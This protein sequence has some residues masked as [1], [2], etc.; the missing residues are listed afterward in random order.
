MKTPNRNGW[1]LGAVFADDEMRLNRRGQAT[2]GNYLLK[3][4]VST[5]GLRSYNWSA[6]CLV[7]NGLTLWAATFDYRILN[8]NDLRFL[9]SQL[10]VHS[11]KMDPCDLIRD[12][13]P[14]M[15][16]PSGLTA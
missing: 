8:R 7:Y 11:G 15:N 2:A 3:G 9:V 10:D 12:Q 6:V 14:V 16:D 5:I 13:D 1:G 4:C